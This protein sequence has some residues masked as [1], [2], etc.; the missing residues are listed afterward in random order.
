LAFCVS[1]KSSCT[2]SSS[3]FSTSFLP[4][5]LKFTLAKRSDCRRSSPHPV[6]L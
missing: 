4:S 1:V 3:S 2:S 6:W 5:S